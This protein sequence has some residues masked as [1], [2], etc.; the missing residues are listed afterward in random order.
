MSN[1]AR[2]ITVFGIY[3]AIAGLS[4]FLVPNMV[5]LPLGFPTT[6]E[7]WIRLT[8]LLTAILGMYFLYSVRYDDRHFFRATIFARLIFFTGVTTI[9]ILR[10]GS[11]LLIVFGLVDLAGAGWTWFALRTQ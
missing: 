9:V 5:L 3:L 1:P 2:S 7:V 4:F 8:G 11:P 10:L 6:T